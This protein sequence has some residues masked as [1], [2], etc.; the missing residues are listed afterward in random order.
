MR[1]A[2]IRFDYSYAGCSNRTSIAGSPVSM[3]R[4]EKYKGCCK[5]E[6]DGPSRSGFWPNGERRV[7]RIARTTEIQARR[8]ATADADRI[9]MVNAALATAKVVSPRGHGAAVPRRADRARLSAI[10]P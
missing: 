6:C 7:M 5:A 10:M 1:A 9:E 2:F 4:E 3:S 8:R